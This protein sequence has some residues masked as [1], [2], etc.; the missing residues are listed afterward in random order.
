M[1]HL[2]G[3]ELSIITLIMC[4]AMIIGVVMPVTINGKLA[5]A[6]DSKKDDMLEIKFVKLLVRFAGIF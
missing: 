5:M 3:L 2:K 4:N 1:F 6:I